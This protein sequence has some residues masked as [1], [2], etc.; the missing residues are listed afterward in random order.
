LCAVGCVL[1]CA[2]VHAL[3][4]AD[5]TVIQLTATDRLVSLNGL[6]R[7][8]AG[9]NPGWAAADFDDSDWIATRTA[10]GV[11][12]PPPPGWNGVGWFRIR[13]S[14]DAELAARS[15]AI[16]TRQSGASEVYVDGRLVQ[17][18]G[19][20]G[21][22]YE[23]ERP[24][25]QVGYEGT[26]ATLVALSAGPHTVAVRYSNFTAA[27]RQHM[28]AVGFVLHVGDLDAMAASQQPRR[29][30]AVTQ[31]GFTVASLTFA[32]LHLALFVFYPRIRTTVN[33]CVNSSGGVLPVLLVGLSDAVDVG[34]SVCD[35]RE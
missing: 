25:L 26:R 9:D 15:V 18:D 4:P 34:S 14:L 31:V 11:D 30:A 33:R 12:P 28:E 10:F 3:P 21:R 1:T 32:V 7:F 6:W 8:H 16:W 22:D 2:R 24:Y 20:V 23:S 29:L 19:V 5:D 17:S 27:R 13:L 35:L